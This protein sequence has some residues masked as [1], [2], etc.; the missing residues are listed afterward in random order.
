[1][2]SKK[3]TLYVDE[4]ISDLAKKVSRQS[5]KSV[6]SL[7]K[8][9]ILAKARKSEKLELP[10]SVSRWIGAVESEKTYKELREELTGDRLKKYERIR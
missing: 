1:M 8:D 10:K 7:V 2:A 6:S 3:L 4:E 9:F 5:G